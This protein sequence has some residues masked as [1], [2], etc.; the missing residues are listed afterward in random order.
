VGRFRLSD[1]AW[2]VELWIHYSGG[3]RRDDDTGK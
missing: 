2:N 1:I 3:V